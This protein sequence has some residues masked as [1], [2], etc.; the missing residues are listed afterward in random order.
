MGLEQ[1]TGG[2]PVVEIPGR[3][4]PVEEYRLEDAIEATGYVCEPESPFALGGAPGGRGGGR[5]GGGRG[6]R[7]GGGGRGGGTRA[8]SAAAAIQ[9]SMFSGSGAEIDPKMRELYPG[10]AEATLKCLQT[11]NE[12]VINYELV[13]L[14]IRHIADEYDDGAILVFLPGMAEIRTLNEMLSSSLTEKQNEFLLIPLHSTLT[15]EEQRRTFSTPPPGVRK[16][17]PPVSVSVLFLTSLIHPPAAGGSPRLFTWP[18]TRWF[19]GVLPREKVVMATNIA[20]TSITIDDV[21][22]V[23]DCGRVKEMRYDGARRMASLE[24][25]WVSRASARQRRGRAGRVKPGYCF[26]MFSSKQEALLEDFTQAEIMRV[27]LS[28]APLSQL[29]HPARRRSQPQC[30]VSQLPC[31]PH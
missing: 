26:H 18:N 20:E 24:T 21:V 3:T 2:C 28:L 6:D 9:D 14:L 7:G 29:S 25:V 5:G 19:V 22:F 10:Y 15:S 17:H 13:E 8:A 31:N 1:V 4:F 27:R 23:I 12:E 30:S 11:V 16:V